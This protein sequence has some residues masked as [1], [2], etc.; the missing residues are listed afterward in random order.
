MWAGGLVGKLL[1]R[2]SASSSEDAS[3]SYVSAVDRYSIT[4]YFDIFLNF[5]S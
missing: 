4:S 2:F 3:T 5:P 1:S